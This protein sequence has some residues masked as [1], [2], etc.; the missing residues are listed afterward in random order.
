MISILMTTYNGEKYVAAQIDSLLRQTVNDFKLYIRDDRSTDDTYSIISEYA[1]KYPDQI[2][3]R[4]NEVNTGGAKHNF[5]QMMIE[6]KDDYLLL[7]DQDDVWMPDKIEKSLKKIKAMELEYGDILPLMVFT[8]L[9]VID[10]DMNVLSPSY[11]KMSNTKSGFIRLN[12]LL[13]M[14]IPTG[15]TI[16]YNRA[17]ADLICDEPDFTVMHDWWISLIAASFGKIG[18]I[19]EQTVMYRQHRDN[20]VG[21]KRALSPKYIRY[22]LTHV[23]IMAEKINNSYK[24]A[25]SFLKLYKS[26]LTDEQKELIAAHAN[27]PNLTK[28][29][30]LRKMLKYK[31]F[32]YGIARK[33]AQ[34]IV[35]LKVR[36]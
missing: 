4:Q 30:K 1:L 24:Q 33:T 36:S 6:H 3:V 19:D 23:D 34:V 28:C 27:M 26:K 20:S 31:T 10:D 13:T 8:D 22:V 18:A 14:N 5:I 35:I 17:L 32:M 11:R 29:G 21:A 16:M 15:C 25:G 9:S 12:N 7:C 2:S